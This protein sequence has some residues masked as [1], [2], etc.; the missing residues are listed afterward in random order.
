MNT[1]DFRE[2]SVWRKSMDIVVDIYAFVRSLPSEEK[3]CL[4]DQIRRCSISIPSNIA[5]GHNRNSTKDYI[6]FL[7]ISRGSVAELQTQ[8]ILSMRLGYLAEDALSFFYMR[9]VEIDKMLSSLMR[10]LYVILKKQKEQ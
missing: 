5:E 2:L 9:L 3:Y 7:S 4:G 10:S 1:S 8:L 6:R